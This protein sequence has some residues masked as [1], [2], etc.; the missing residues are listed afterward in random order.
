MTGL[1]P[2]LLGVLILL[3]VCGL[4]SMIEIALVLCR[5]SRLLPSQDDDDAR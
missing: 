1:L 3:F 2:A 5:E 4:L